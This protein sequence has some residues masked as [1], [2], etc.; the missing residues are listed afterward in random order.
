[1]TTPE[2]R[3]AADAASRWLAGRQLPDGSLVRG[4]RYR[5]NVGVTALSGLALAA[6]GSVPTGGPHAAEVAAAARFLLDNQGSD[7]LFAVADA[8]DAPPDA[9]MY[10]HGFAL[11]FLSEVL[12]ELDEPTFDPAKA[13]AAVAA[14]VRRTVASQTADGG[15]RYTPF[16]PEA[17]ISVT[18]CQIAALRAADEAGVRVPPGVVPAAAGY[19]RRCR[20]PAD[21]GFF[22]R[23]GFPDRSGFARSAA[24]VSALQT[25]GLAD[26][27]VGPEIVG[28]LRYLLANR[29]ESGGGPYPFYGRYYGTSAAWQAG[30][31]TW[32]AW[33]PFVREDLLRT[34]VRADGAV[35]WRSRSVCD[36]YAT[37]LAVLALRVPERLLPIFRR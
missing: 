1:M 7:G 8:P 21:G 28:G 36:E 19:V 10:G 4:S 30:G 17:D 18:V 32:A 35:Y 25:A 13:R 20:N 23:A 12:G 9:V 3:T 31:E 27:A 2:S 6:G 16:T 22:Y 11:L 24:A 5:R 34:A 37:A 14:G 33:F 29:G 15:W 26:P